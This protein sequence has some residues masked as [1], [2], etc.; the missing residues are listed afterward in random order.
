[1]ICVRVEAYSVNTSEVAY[2]NVLVPPESVSSSSSSYTH[3]KLDVKVFLKTEKMIVQ[4][5]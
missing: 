2:F 1:M 3:T 5:I 4:Q